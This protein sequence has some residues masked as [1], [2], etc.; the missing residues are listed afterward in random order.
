MLERLKRINSAASA[1]LLYAGA[2]GLILMTAVIGWQ[3]SAASS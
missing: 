2:A 1:A 3:C